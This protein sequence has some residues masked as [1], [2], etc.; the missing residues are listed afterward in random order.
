MGGNA[1][2]KRDFIEMIS[3]KNKNLLI[4]LPELLFFVCLSVC[5]ST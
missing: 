3:K 5:L 4:I 2:E 1:L